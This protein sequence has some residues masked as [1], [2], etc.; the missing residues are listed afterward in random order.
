MK[1]K[2]LLFCALFL[3]LQLASQNYFPNK[4]SEWERLETTKPGF[5][6]EKLSEAIKFINDN[7]YSGSRDLRIA[8]LESFKREPFHTIKGP[9]KK[10]K[11][12]AGMILKSGKVVA[13]WGDVKEV[14]MTFSVTKSYLIVH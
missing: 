6:K 12:P 5:D 3:S 7:E 10:R 1:Y 14:E 8:I 2:I 9:T 4:S 13:S 11:G